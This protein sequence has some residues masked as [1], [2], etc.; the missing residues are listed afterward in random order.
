MHAGPLAAWQ[1]FVQALNGQQRAAALARAFA[2]DAQVRRFGYHGSRDEVLEQFAG[3]AE[4]GAWL[5]RTPATI[6]FALCAETL[7][8]LGPQ[9]WSVRYRL[10]AP[11][12]F[13][14]GG[15]WI[16]VLGG[17]GRWVD[18]EHRP[19]DLD[20]KYGAPVAERPRDGHVHAHAQDHAHA[21]AP[22]EG[23]GRADP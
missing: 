2:A 19:D 5:D 7:T 11:D 14:G 20:P 12:D 10:T 15:L 6:R 8:P 4:L 23:S 9:R 1:A 18:L 17:D 3:L 21:H 13:V 16:G 22:G